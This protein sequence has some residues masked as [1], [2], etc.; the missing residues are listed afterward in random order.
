MTAAEIEPRFLTKR[1]LPPQH[2]QSAY[3]A[4]PSFCNNQLAYSYAL[5]TTCIAVLGKPGI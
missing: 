1:L 5:V 2:T 4:A 3:R